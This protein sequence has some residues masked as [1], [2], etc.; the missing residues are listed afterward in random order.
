MKE[1]IEKHTITSSAVRIPS[2]P[3]ELM[4]G[5]V[6]W[7]V[8]IGYEGRVASIY[9][10]HGMMWLPEGK[11]KHPSSAFQESYPGEF[12]ELRNI[13]GK[14]N[15]HGKS[16][17]LSATYHKPDTIDVLPSLAMDCQIATNMGSMWDFFD[18][19]GIEPS[20]EGEN[21]Y[22]VMKVNARKLR[23]VFGEVVYNEFLSIEGEE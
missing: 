22:N 15:T 12:K 19:F 10:S 8:S 13:L 23:H 17:L 6:H 7:L 18:E 9:F 3:D 2:R 1:F 11:T 16:R 5:D 20:R 4:V 21:A 14:L